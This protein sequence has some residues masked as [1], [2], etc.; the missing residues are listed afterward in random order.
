MINP[1]LVLVAVAVALG[2]VAAVGARD[3]RTALL[4]LAVALAGTPFLAAP[5]PAL[6]TLAVR[7]V[8]AALASYLLR[9]VVYLDSDE[10][11][12]EPR[13]SDAAAATIG[14]SRLGWPADAAFAAAAGVVG[15]QLAVSIQLLQPTGPGIAA[16]D[17]RAYLT[18]TA[19]AV[20]G[21][22]VLLVA[23][24]P[25]AL[26]GLAP[27]R[28]TIG[29]LIV[30]QGLGLLR[31]GLAG[32]PGDLEQLSGVV[33]LVALAAAGAYLIARQPAGVRHKGQAGFADAAAGDDDAPGGGGTRHSVDR[34]DRSGRARLGPGG[35][36]R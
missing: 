14:G 29:W 2:A 28:A 11:G 20:G 36:D 10:P 6:S 32:V 9:A 16:N 4:G 5:L 30:L 15:L 19:L 26:R 35:G 34:P 12:G 23:G 31:A 3:P 25:A 8:G 22:L 17:V 13:L 33:L 18:P 1:V 21:G 24:L 7:V 27:L